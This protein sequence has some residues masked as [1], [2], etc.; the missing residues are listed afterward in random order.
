MNSEPIESIVIVGGGTAGWM[1]AASL[2]RFV[3]NKRISITLIESLSIGT[4]GVGEATVPN[5]VDFNRSLGIDEI[6][7]IKATQ[8]TFK[9]G[10]QFENWSQPGSRFFHPFAG[11]GLK[12]DNVE[13]HQYLHRLRANGEA[14]ELEDYSF[15]CMLAKQGRFAQPHPNPPTPLAEYSYAYHFDASLYAKFLRDF[16]V[17]RGVKHVDAKIGG[18]D[19]HKDNGF[20][21][22]VTLDDGRVISG[23][24]FIDCSGFKGLLIEGAL[25]TGYESWDHWLYCDSALAVQTRR[26]G[27]PVP[28]TRTIARDFGW[29]WRIPLQHRTGNGYLFSSRFETDDNAKKTLEANIEGEALTDIRKITFTPGRRKK[30]WNKNCFALGLAGGFLEPLESTSISLIQTAISKLLTFF[31]DKSFNQ[32]DI[33]E[34]N[35]LHNNEVEHIRDFIILHYKLNNRQD[36][37]F[38]RQCHDMPVPDTLAHKM[39]VYESRGH[40][41]MYDNESFELASWLTMYNGFN[42]V[43]KRVDERAYA[44]DGNVLKNKLHQMQLSL[45]NAAEQAL[46]HDQFIQKHCPAKSI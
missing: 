2:S 35:R 3:A 46:T 1:A 16:S 45:R 36:T 7:F 9:L 27:E 11:Y 31:P 26:V 42:R 39:A 38:W 37:G 44:V 24:L 18:V 12:M 5:I 10:I 32:A 15:S 22:S 25:K 8:A 33:E 43:P 4:V 28:Y 13:F 14:V 40:F 23:D 41:V 19:L 21:K 29:Q 30:I 34:A 20:I 17:K 6:E